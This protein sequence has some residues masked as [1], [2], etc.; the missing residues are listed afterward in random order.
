MAVELG[1][2]YAVTVARLLDECIFNKPVHHRMPE[3]SW[4]NAAVHTNT[5]TMMEVRRSALLTTVDVMLFFGSAAIAAKYW[6]ETRTRIL[7]QRRLG[8]SCR[9]LGYRA[10]TLLLLGVSNTNRALSLVLEA[11]FHDV[12]AH[13]RHRHRKYP[14]HRWFDY[15]VVSFP[16]LIWTSMLSLLLLYIVET[17]HRAR[18]RRVTL[19]RPTTVFVNA[20][21]YLLYSTLAVITWG[22][23]AWDFFRR[24]AYLLLGSLQ[25]LISFLFAWYGWSL[26]QQLRER[27]Q[28]KS[29]LLPTARSRTIIR[30]LN[31]V[32]AILSFS[33]LVR[34]ASDLCYM[35]GS[36]GFT[37]K[38]GSGSLIAL[39]IAKLCLEWAPSVALLVALQPWPRDP[40]GRDN[41]ALEDEEDFVRMRAS[42]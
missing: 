12:Y 40:G 8:C 39:A 28:S 26:T 15:L 23:Q 34:G 36:F 14:W 2:G 31:H 37:L 4:L 33:E 42:S 6:L 32:L 20:L 19:L 29:P 3:A 18:M 35:Q 9:A 22:L 41:A 13:I 21:V 38:D 1:P 7:E 17:Y 27:M 10:V 11:K 30:R 25:L 5:L 16:T 24:L